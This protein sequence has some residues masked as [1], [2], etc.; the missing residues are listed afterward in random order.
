MKKSVCAIIAAFC[1]SSPVLAQQP[2]YNEVSFDVSIQKTVANDELQATLTKSAEH[3]TA[4]ALANSLNTASNK[5]LELAKKYPNIKVSTGY[6]HSYPRYDNK[7]R[8]KGFTGSASVNVQSQD[9]E[10]ASEFIAEAQSFMTLD[11]LNFGVSDKT[12]KAMEKDLKRELIQNFN[13]EA[14][15]TAQAFGAKNYKL[16]KVNLS[17]GGNYY[18]PPVARTMD[19][20][21]KAVAAA[22]ELSGGDSQITYSASGSIELVY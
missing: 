9:F 20:Q 12:K 10:Q 1:A 18:I 16:V 15:S 7:G 4:K 2:T 5:A 14:K 21:A 3:S 22:P 13:N 17:G 11:G 8:I 6:H 19:A